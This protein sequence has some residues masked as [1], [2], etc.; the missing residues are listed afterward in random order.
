MLERGVVEDNIARHAEVA[1]SRV[2]VTD[3]NNW[4]GTPPNIM[5]QAIFRAL[6]RFT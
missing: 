1:E 6:L 2:E 4:P 3:E 5:L